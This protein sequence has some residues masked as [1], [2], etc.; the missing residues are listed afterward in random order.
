MFLLIQP[1]KASYETRGPELPAARTGIDTW[2]LTQERLDSCNICEK[3]GA[4]AKRAKEV[5][6]GIRERGGDL[7]Y[8][9]RDTMLRLIG[10]DNLEYREL[11]RAA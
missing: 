3:V 9:F 10:S 8:L 5:V 6:I 1:E 7:P 4:Q 11:V 2:L